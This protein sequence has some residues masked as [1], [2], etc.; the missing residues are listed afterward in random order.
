[1]LSREIAV[2]A[3]S[4]IEIVLPALFLTSIFEFACFISVPMI[5]NH[6]EP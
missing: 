4:L 2:W 5:G 1:L 3:S 6:R